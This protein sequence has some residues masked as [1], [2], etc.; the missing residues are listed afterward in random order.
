MFI[1]RENELRLLGDLI[2]SE[3][4][5]IGVIYG[6]RRIGKSELIKKAFENEKVL[7]FEGLENRPKQEQ[8]DNFLFQLYY[9]TKNEFIRNRKATSWQEA[10]LML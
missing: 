6:R 1:G 8:I 9:L 3:K 4:L 10:F 7:I 2:N 5:A